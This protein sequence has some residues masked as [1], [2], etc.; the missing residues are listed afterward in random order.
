[1]IPYGTKLK[2]LS[3]FSTVPLP[4]IVG[5]WNTWAAP[6]ATGSTFRWRYV[7][8]P[9]INKDEKTPELIETKKGKLTSFSWFL[10][11]NV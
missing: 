4:L 3:L 11:K 2:P 8:R 9:A 6:D 10:F 1:M 5:P 7:L